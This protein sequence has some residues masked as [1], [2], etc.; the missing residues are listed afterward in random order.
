MKYDG[1][2]STFKANA[3][4]VCAE[5]I[6]PFICESF[7]RVVA[8]ISRPIDVHSYLR[9]EDIADIIITE[10]INEGINALHDN[11]IR[12]NESDGTTLCS[13][14]LVPAEFQQNIPLNLNSSKGTTAKAPLQATDLPSQELGRS[15]KAICANVGDSRCVMVSSSAEPASLAV[16]RSSTS[17]WP[18]S[19]IRS[20]PSVANLAS[21]GGGSEKRP[22]FPASSSSLHLRTR[23]S[24]PSP[25]SATVFQKMSAGDE[26]NE[27]EYTGS[28]DKKL[29]LK[30]LFFIKMFI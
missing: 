21:S 29:Q 27:L 12:T 9:N 10:A 19:S 26:P 1:Y 11:C 18:F 16:K 28:G 24:D 8:N 17:K 13:L 6:R 30:Y 2:H 5:N 22:A 15:Y 4:N 14:F 3:A 7:T 20:S 25:P 23:T